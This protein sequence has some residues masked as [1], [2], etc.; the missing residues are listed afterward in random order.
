M[1][2]LPKIIVI[3]GPTGSG[4][5]DMGIGIAKKFNGEVVSADSRQIYK[6]MDIGTAKPE[7]KLLDDAYVVGGMPHYLMGIVNPDESFTLAD[8][9]QLAIA[10][11]HEIL[12]RKKL[13]IIVGGTGLYIQSVVENLDMPKVV[14][15]MQLRSDLEARSPADRIGMLKKIDPDSAARM[16]LNNPRR[17]LRA[18]EVAL[19]TGGSFY[20]QRKKGK[21]LFDVLEIGIRLPRPESNAGLDLRVDRQIKEGLVDE[22]KNLSKKY[23]WDLPSMS[24][25]GYKQ[26]GYYLRGQMGLEDAVEEIKK[27]TRRYAKRQM[28]W[29]K[30]DKKINWLDG[31]D[32]QKAEELVRNFINDAGERNGLL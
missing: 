29:F 23:S 5:T 17:V 13:P 30:R 10:R 11:I 32:L 3:L 25:I 2:E 12:G 16:D 27:D 22:V 15:D 31:A 6:G 14:P 8:F 9:K 18:L 20:N 4:K 28:T 7:G 24:G 21:P 26:V 1:N 19:T